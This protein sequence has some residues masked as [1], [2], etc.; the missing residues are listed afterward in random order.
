MCRIAHLIARAKELGMDSL[1]ITDHG[2]M[3]GVID[4]YVAAKEAGIK[5]IIGCEVYVAET[6]CRSRES[7]HKTPYHLTLLAKNEK[8]YRNLLQLVTKSQLEGFYYRPRVDKELLKLHHGGLIALS[9]CAHGELARLI[10]EGRKDE[11]AR[12]ALW[13]K[14]VFGDYYLEIQRRMGGSER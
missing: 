7:A 12:T 1:A 8:G 6:D 3:Y 9:G 4:F 11:L 5:P 2:G 10:L 14:E 13:Y